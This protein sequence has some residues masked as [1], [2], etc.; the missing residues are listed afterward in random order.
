MSRD[1]EHPLNSERVRNYV[2]TICLRAL[3]NLHD[4]EDVTQDVLLEALHD[5][6]TFDTSKPVWGFICKLAHNELW[7]FIEK[8]SIRL[9]YA[10]RMACDPLRC[11]SSTTDPHDDLECKELSVLIAKVLEHCGL[12]ERTIL[13]RVVMDDALL[14]DVSREL[15]LSETHARRL[16]KSA[17]QIVRDRLPEGIA[18][19]ASDV[20]GLPDGEEALTL[21]EL[22]ASIRPAVTH[23]AVRYWIRRGLRSEV[24]GST[25]RLESAKRGAYLYSS[26]PAY[27]RFAERVGRLAG[28]PGDSTRQERSSVDVDKHPRSRQHNDADAGC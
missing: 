13:H 20:T 5:W 10:D 9:K 7:R 19:Y 26:L 12:R 24:N 14:T 16:K 23:H 17:L 6:H 1:N 25:V 18:E 27:E 4:A 11:R 2:F 22:G 15:R 8:R 28:R 21:A 3:Q